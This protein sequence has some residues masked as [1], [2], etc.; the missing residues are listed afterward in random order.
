MLGLTLTVLGTIHAG[1]IYLIMSAKLPCGQVY[2]TV[3][4]GQSLS[5]KVLFFGKALSS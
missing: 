2:L 4:S 1:E 3:I 5:L